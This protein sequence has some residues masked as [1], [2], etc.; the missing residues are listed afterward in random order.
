MLPGKVQP[1]LRQHLEMVRRQHDWDLAQGL[2]RVPLPER[3]PASIP[4]PTVSG[5]GNGSFPP[6]RTTWT[7][8]RGYAKRRSKGLKSTL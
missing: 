5:A 1:A 6:P 3:W 8:I 7:A 2:G 4:T